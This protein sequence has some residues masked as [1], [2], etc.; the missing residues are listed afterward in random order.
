LGHSAQPQLTSQSLKEDENRAKYQGNA[1]D[2]ATD[3]VR[4]SLRL[5]NQIEQEKANDQEDDEPLDP[6][7]LRLL[8]LP[9]L[10]ADYSNTCWMYRRKPAQTHEALP[11]DQGRAHRLRID[12]D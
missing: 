5:G 8:I 6:R 12:V 9:I 11:H 3:G 1:P 2:Y 10:I 7:H 4:G